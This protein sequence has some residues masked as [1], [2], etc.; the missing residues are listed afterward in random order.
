MIFRKI[1]ATALLSVA[2]VMSDVSLG[3]EGSLEYDV[4]GNGVQSPFTDGLLLIRYLFG[5]SGDALISGAIGS[6][7]ERDTAEE[8]EAYIK[9]RVPTEDGVADAPFDLDGDGRALP[10][11]DGLLL[12]RAMAGACD[13]SGAVSSSA[14]RTTCTDILS[15][16]NLAFPKLSDLG[17]GSNKENELTL[18]VSQQT[19]NP[20]RLN[21]RYSY[22]GEESLLGFAIWIFYDSTQVTGPSI[23]ETEQATTG[24]ILGSDPVFVSSSGRFRNNLDVSNL[25]DD[26]ST[27]NFLAYL[28]FPGEVTVEQQSE[29]LWSES[30]AVDF[31]SSITTTSVLS[32]VVSVSSNVSVSQPNAVEI[33]RLDTDLDGVIDY[34]D[35][36]PLDATETVDTDSDGTGNNADTDDDGDGVLDTADAFALISLG[37]LTDTDDDGRPNDCDND[38]QTLGMTADT[39]DDGDGYSDAFESNSGTNALDALSYPSSGGYINARAWLVRGDQ[40]SAKAKV[41][42]QRLFSS[43][44][45]VSVNF[46]TLDGVNSKAGDAYVAATGTLNWLEGDE[47][48]KVIEIDLISDDQYSSHNFYVELYDPSPE[49]ALLGWKTMIYYDGFFLNKKLDDFAGFLSLGESESTF[50]EGTNNVIW[51]NRFQASNGTAQIK[52]SITGCSGY[53]D[54]VSSD[55]REAVITWADGDAEPKPIQLNFLE[56]ELNLNRR[57]D[58]TFRVYLSEVEPTA[59]GFNSAHVL[60]N[61]GPEF[62][63]YN[64]DFDRPVVHAAQALMGTSEGEK[65][66][67]I[68]IV[69]RGPP[70]R[71]SVINI[72]DTLDLTGYSRYWQFAKSGTHFDYPA[73][74]ETLTWAEGDASTKSIFLSTIDDELLERDELVVLEPSGDD[75]DSWRYLYVYSLSDEPILLDGDIDQDGIPDREDAD[76]DGDGLLDWWD[77]D[78]DGDGYSLESDSHWWDP[79]Q[80]IDSDYDGVAD[81]SDAFPLDATETLD[82]DADG[83]GNNADPDDDGDGIGDNGDLYPNDPMLWSMKLEDA[84]ASIEDDKLRSCIENPD[85]GSD[86]GA[87]VQVADV[88]KIHCNPPISTLAGVENFSELQVLTVD[89][90]FYTDN[91]SYFIN[92]WLL[93]R[94][95]LWDLTPLTGL[96]RMSSLTLMNTKVEDIS[97]L[98]S[99]TGL[100]TLNLANSQREAPQ[101]TDISPLSS[102]VKLRILE[103]GGHN[104]SDISPLKDLNYLDQ[105][106]LY[107]NNIS[108]LAALPRPTSGV[109]S[110]IFGSPGILVLFINGNPI[111]DYAVMSDIDTYT[112]GISVNSATQTSFLAEYRPWQSLYAF[113][114]GTAVSNFDFLQNSVSFGCIEC[115]LSDDGIITNLV[116]RVNKIDQFSYLSLYRNNIRDLQP[117]ANLSYQAGYGTLDLRANPVVSLW[118]LAESNVTEIYAEQTALLCSHIEE[119]TAATGKNVTSFTCLSNDGDEDGDGFP[120]VNDAFPLDTNETV[121]TDSD[122]TGNN[123]DPDDDND[124]VLDT[125]DAFPLI[126]L[127]G[128]TDTDGDGRPNDCDSACVTLGMTADSDDDNDGVLDTADAFPLISLGSLTDTDGDG[129]PNDCDSDCVTLGMTA[130]TDDDGDGVLD[131][132]DAFPLNAAESIDTDSDGTGN[133]ADTDDDG[134]GVADTS[135]AFPLDATETLDTDADGTGNNADPDDDGDGVLDT[136]DA[137][138]LDATE[139]IDTDGDG[140]GD[141]YDED[142]DGDGVVDFKSTV[143]VGDWVFDGDG[144]WIE[145]IAP[146]DFSRGSFNLEDDP[147]GCWFDDVYRF[148]SNGDFR[149]LLG[150]N[151]YIY[152]FQTNYEAPYLSCAT[153]IFPYDGS[154]VGQY[155][156]VKEEEELFLRGRG[157]FIGLA[158]VLDDKLWP[159]DVINPIGEGTVKNK[160]QV[161]QLDEKLMTL[162]QEYSF[163]TWVTMRLRCIDGCEGTGRQSLVD[164]FP[165]DRTEWEDTDGDGLGNNSDTDDDND[166]VSD[167][168]DAYP[169]ISLGE[170]IDTDG[171]G[172]PNDCDSVCQTLGMTADTDDDNDGV[173]DT[174]DAFPLDAFESIDTDSDGT[175]NSADTDD[176]GD[177]VSDESDT[178]PLDATESVDTDSDGTGNNAD[179]DD[180]NDGVLDTAD[181]FSLISLGSLTDTDGDGR[182]ND[183]DSDC[184]TLGMTADTDDD[185]DGVLDTADAFSLISLGSLTD[186]DGDGRP[187][188]CDSDC[189]RWV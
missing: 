22:Q 147:Q 55:P 11:T 15:F 82:T 32:K 152:G 158:G 89:S 156:Y 30:F 164:A 67:E 181:A 166:G 25:D 104:I 21:F 73:T 56:N 65:E 62:L 133:N 12:I 60:L 6:G 13:E 111:E 105:L 102:L 175:G 103:L 142:K 167:A 45:A 5:F 149:N 47:Q 112:L 17:F 161:L 151:T 38:C 57:L 29:A 123:A 75:F 110:A 128:R 122:G 138:P 100:T 116:D 37:S 78:R 80:S 36:F 1:W 188:D 2:L 92:G 160:F 85:A 115:G 84:I 74:A 170:L 145:G 49:G 7:A 76:M 137:F 86:L 95:E 68:K 121:D 9:E 61:Y 10:L 171:D 44:G 119:F 51:L 163:G 126:S 176:D 98:T 34:F 177:G 88:I 43:K 143:I 173:L 108:D 117:L 150:D 39:D 20:S 3:A 64:N 72:A 54:E 50:G 131:G 71:E 35:A 153:P 53:L 132:S 14:P 141:N 42:V 154:D 77:L 165:L 169:L 106:W 8:V 63:V 81:T 99:L 134:D 90:T 114:E 120:N 70:I 113:G 97:P 79:N 41:R 146:N 58:C 93:P 135:D 186:T 31:G 18:S 52:Y 96:H 124:G 23:F 94:G 172:R 109:F 101:I 187:N 69:R 28:Y 130:D 159:P 127:G 174:A 24:I 183:C 40:L 162:A 139:S 91:G 140:V 59:A 182:P 136:A 185:N 178:F 180:D 33:S 83:T 179:P 125:A 27:D 4:D 46:R 184:Q 144:S 155:R 66:V 118:P 107:D 168:L 48:E 148:Q 87:G 19:D 26:V 189:Q 129:R 16:A 157:S